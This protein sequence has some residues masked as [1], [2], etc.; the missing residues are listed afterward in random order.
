MKYS[1]AFLDDVEKWGKDGDL[2]TYVHNLGIPLLFV[3][4]SE[5]TSVSPEESESLAAVH[6]Q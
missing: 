2:P 5:D 6:P 4:G 1:T 3:H